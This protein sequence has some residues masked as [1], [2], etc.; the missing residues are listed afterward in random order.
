M[1]P[2]W[3]EIECEPCKR[4]WERATIAL[5]LT[6]LSAQAQDDGNLRVG[7][8][9]ELQLSITTTPNGPVGL[10]RYVRADDGKY[11]RLNITSE[12]DPALAARNA[13]PPPDFYW[14][15]GHD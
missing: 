6:V 3:E 7:R 12:G 8:P 4:S 14:P 10:S 15:A 11:Y 2:M 13:G 5:G 1:K 9:T